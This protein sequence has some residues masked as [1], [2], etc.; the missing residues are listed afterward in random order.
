[1]ARLLHVIN[2][3]SGGGAERQLTLLAA[4]QLARGH[5][6]HIA[7]MRPDIP[8]ALA[9][10]GVNVHVMRAAS[11]HDPLHFWRLRL[12]MTSVR[13]HIVQTWLTQ[14]DVMGG[15]AALSTRT[16]WV[17]SERSSTAGYPPNWKNSLRARLARRAA[18][19]VA[20]SQG[21]VDYWKAQGVTPNRIHKVHNVVDTLAI[22]DAAVAPLPPAFEGRPLVVFAGRLAEEKNPFVMIDALAE[23][24][25]SNNALAL[26]CGTGPLQSSMA[27]RIEALGVRDR[28]VLAGHRSDVFGLLQRATLCLA[29]SRY[30]GSPNVVLEAMAAGCPLVVSD[31]PAYTELLDAESAMVVERDNIRDTAR[32]I[33]EVIE[34][35]AAA[36]NRAARARLRIASF[37]AENVAGALDVLYDRL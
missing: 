30:E 13:A 24:F 19:I 7:V 32:A 20:N 16:P 36:A 10:I 23:A 12:L 22:R 11:N 26:L 3:L 21:G 9:N 33:R 1:M 17:L 35:P 18:A 29:I 28:I 6:V 14:S 5:E 25:Q 15:L 34:H 37:T 4:A 2:G 31:I 8:A 27:S